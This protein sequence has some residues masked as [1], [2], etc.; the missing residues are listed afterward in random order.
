M[1][2]TEPF[3]SDTPLSQLGEEKLKPPKS[4]WRE[5]FESLL[6][7]PSAVV[8]LLILASLVLI[9]IFAPLVVTHDPNRVLLD[10][11][12]EGA[13]R[14]MAPCIH[15]LGC[16]SAGDELLSISTEQ[17]Y[18]A[19]SLNGTGSELLV[20]DGNSVEIW[21]TKSQT[22][23]FS[24]D[25]DAPVV[26]AA[27]SS[28]DQEILTASGE[29]LFIWSRSGRAI[30][31]T[32]VH[33][34]GANFV[35]WSNDGTR[36]VSAND[37]GIYFWINCKLISYSPACAGRTQSE[38]TFADEGVYPLENPWTAIQWNSNG[39]MLMVASGNKVEML[40]SAGGVIRASATFEHDNAVTRARFNRQSSRI[41]TVSGNKAY[42]WQAS[43]PFELVRE[44][45]Y[46][47]PLIEATWSEQTRKGT[48]VVRV[49]GTSDD[50]LIVWN[51]NTGEMLD[52]FVSD[53]GEFIGGGASLF[54]TQIV[55][56]TDDT[57]S[58]WD[59]ETTEL[60][61]SK[62]LNDHIKSVF[63]QNNTGGSASV[64]V[65]AEKT[66]KVIKTSNY[67]Y[68]M[69]VDGNSRDEFSRLI[70]GTR[71]SLLVGIISVTLAIVSG[72]VLGALAGF[73]G[74]WIDNIIMRSMDVVLAFPSLI[75]A[76][77]VVT[78]IDPKSFNFI[79][80]IPILKVLDIHIMT[81]LVA[82]S[83]VSIPAY[84]R[85]AR[86][87][88]LSVKEYDFVM[89]DRA[90]GVSP[91]RI[92]FR[93][94]LPNILAPLIVQATLGIG[95]AILDA[96]ALSFLGLGAQRPTAEWGLMLSEERAQFQTA[97]HLVF[98]PGIAIAIV[99]LAFNLLG[100]GLRDALD[101]RL[102]R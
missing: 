16:P 5:T 80:S 32:Y 24:L 85:V 86:A 77:A 47:R 35:A 93:R 91:R 31:E 29:N 38:M 60:I 96:A 20:S 49:I 42:I 100:D 44:F 14:R 66:L 71:V 45:E 17:S 18:G 82:I 37:K 26:A 59:S 53:A 75:L 27:W 28:T 94:I 57:I 101:P 51:A 74:G 4:L 98:F 36:F 43:S 87:G 8:G 7:K 70:Y 13:S 33:E 63:W 79:K 15:L 69:G 25:H 52:T 67:Q 22:K 102:N 39:T 50:G 72:T 40:S 34:G 90:L 1:Q 54:A 3:V 64:V 30:L 58:L 97:P 95:T 12:E 23:L 19:A 73:V 11:P 48:T 10:V 21:S 81:A 83:V 56:F 61:F 9:A 55:G 6:R 65:V 68:I 84:A 89:A 2:T 99:V 41:L 88:V 78:I 46:S 76:I 62:K 92:L